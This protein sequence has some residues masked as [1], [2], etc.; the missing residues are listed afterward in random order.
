[1]AT[2]V[3][4]TLIIT[5]KLWSHR[6]F[7]VENLG[8]TQRRSQAQK[9]LDILVESGFVYCALQ[10]VTLTLDSLPDAPRQGTSYAY[11]VQ[12]FL[13]S[14]TV[15]SAMYPTIIIVLVNTQRSFVDTYG[16]SEAEDHGHVQP[17]SQYRPATMGH[18]SFAAGP[19]TESTANT[20]ATFNAVE[21]GMAFSEGLDRV[22]DARRNAVSAYF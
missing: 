16:F 7:V 9:V 12:V 10:V 8:N 19:Q 20:E 6:K 18:L 15:V 11:A 2:N 13:C 3:V 22:A 21:K 14:Y 1:M 17:D 4:T 5:Y